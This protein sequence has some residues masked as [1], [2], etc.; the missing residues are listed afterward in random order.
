MSAP[1]RRRAALAGALSL[2]LMAGRAVAQPDWPRRPVRVVVPYAPGGATDSSIRVISDR[3]GAALGQS[4]VVENRSGGSGLIG[5]GAVVQS[6]P[7]GYT[8]LME[9]LP[10]AVNP[11]LLRNAPFDYRTA[12]QPVTQVTR[13]P[14]ALVV[15]HD[16]PARDVA[17]FVALARRRPGELSCGYSG[18]GT[19]A[20]L[21]GVLLQLRANIQLTPVVYRGGADAVRDLA[22]GALDCATVAL[23][24]AAP[25]AQSGRVRILAVTSP[26]R[27]PLVPDLPTL[28]EGGVPDSALDEWMGLFAP[29]GTPAAIRDR[30]AAAVAG[31]L[32]EPEV[33][34]RLAQ[35][36]A[37]PVGSTPA[38]FAAFVAQGRDAAERLVREARIEAN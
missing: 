31:V 32:R 30:M 26:R 11:F 5:A 12:L 29:A 4:I 17:E 19:G 2:P 23:L 9:G 7:D 13:L 3:L 34:A 37:E 25:V 21:A 14:L 10:S 18:N 6:A 28:V 24:S 38:D 36:G 8:F 20:H 1:L 35:L 16:L 33:V 15:K 22:A 27:S